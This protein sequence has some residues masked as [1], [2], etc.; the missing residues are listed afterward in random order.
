MIISQT[1]NEWDELRGNLKEAE[2]AWLAGML[3]GE[4]HLGIRRGYS[5]NTNKNQRATSKKEWVWY[6]PR[7][8]MNNTHIP[9]MEKS[10]IM[11]NGTLLKRKPIK[12]NYCYIYTVEVGAR[13]K[14]I[15]LLEKVIPHMVTKREIAN[16]ILE[17]CKL[18]R[19]SGL[20]K[21]RLYNESIILSQADTSRELTPRGIGRCDGQG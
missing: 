11:M 2:W 3:D 17:F 18:P 12:S 7:I 15:E 8:S 16:L 19:G 20:E 10:A 6:A 4:G 9:T 13:E 14:C 5:K 21:E 1:L